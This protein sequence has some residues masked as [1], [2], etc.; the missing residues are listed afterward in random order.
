MSCTEA[1]AAIRAAIESETGLDAAIEDH[2]AACDDCREN[3]GDRALEHALQ[4]QTVAPPRDGFVDQ[5][6]ASAIHNGAMVRVRRFG[7]A[8]SIAV[9]GFVLGVTYRSYDNSDLERSSISGVTLAAH[10]GKTVRVV[11]NSPSEQDSATV[12]IELG[13]NLEL[14]GFPNEHRIQ[15]QTSLAEGKNLLALPLTLTDPSDS[16]FEVA[17]SYGS[18]IKNVRVLVH[19][20]L[21]KPEL[22]QVEA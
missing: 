18:S 20:A 4:R 7:V 11:I 14:A 8:A 5:A 15:W 6:I 13:D 12:T 22:T 10:E 16:H 2:V 17:L 19:A 3:Y 9:I 1:Q 21:P